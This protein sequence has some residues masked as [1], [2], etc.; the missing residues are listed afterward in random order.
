MKGSNIFYPPLFPLSLRSLINSYSKNFRYRSLFCELKL[1]T[2]DSEAENKNCELKPLRQ[3][4]SKSI[5][6][7]NSL[8]AH[9]SMT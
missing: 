6:Q 3:L 1:I 5:I 2:R 7:A 4:I 9:S 8:I